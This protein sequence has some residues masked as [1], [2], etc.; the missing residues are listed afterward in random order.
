MKQGEKMK[1][2]FYVWYDNLMENHFS[3]EIEQAQEKFLEQ[4][5][6]EKNLILKIEAEGHKEAL[7]TYRE[8]VALNQYQDLAINII[9]FSN[10][11]YTSSKLK[12]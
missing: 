5:L 10:F 2:Q 3:L 8:K 7:T 12:H 4:I 11:A 9:N 1:Q 6:K